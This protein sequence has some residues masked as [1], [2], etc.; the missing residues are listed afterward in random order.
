LQFS[1]DNALMLRVSQGDIAQLGLLFERYYRRLFAFFYRLTG[2]TEQS[3]DMVQMVFERI[4]KYKHT[5]KNEGTFITWLF[6]LARNV[7]AD[8]YKKSKRLGERKDVYHWEER[9]IDSEDTDSIF[10]KRENIQLLENALQK[11]SPDKREILVLSKYEELKYSEIAQ[12]LDC[13][14]ENVKVKVHRA[15][16]EL[17]THCLK[18]FEIQV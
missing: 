9:I 11:L 18:L 17:K 14:E 3:E 2:K 8:E 16:K 5:F 4:L 10:Q 12:I 1:D 6:H 15:M 7:Y 13:T